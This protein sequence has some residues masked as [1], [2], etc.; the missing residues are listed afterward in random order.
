MTDISDQLPHPRNIGT[1][2]FPELPSD[3]RLDEIAGSR[4]EAYASAQPY[5]HIVLDGLFDDRVLETVL[6]EFPGPRTKNWTA[7]D[8]PSTAPCFR[9]VQES[10]SKS[11]RGKLPAT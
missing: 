4:A 9:H 5:P 3:E 1:A 8:F 10:G 7:H 11:T 2:A 6:S